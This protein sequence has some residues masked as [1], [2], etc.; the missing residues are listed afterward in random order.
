[1]R[2]VLFVAYL[3]MLQA[4][5]RVCVFISDSQSFRKKHHELPNPNHFVNIVETAGSH[6][7]A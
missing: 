2:L 5:V 4:L 7:F 6:G 3:W 1:M